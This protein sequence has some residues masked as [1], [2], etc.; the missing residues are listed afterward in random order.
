MKRILF[1]VSALVVG[2]TSCV[3]SEDRYRPEETQEEMGKYIFT[4]KV[5]IT[6]DEA[7]LAK[8]NE[9]VV[10]YKDQ[11][12]YRGTMAA[13]IELPAGAQTRADYLD[14]DYE[15]SNVS[16]R[17]ST[18][19][20]WGLL[21]FEDWNENGRTDLDYND[22]V[23]A[24][25]EKI[26]LEST[27]GNG[28]IDKIEAND[29][30]I[31]PV[32]MGN[33]YDLT[34]GYEIR[35]IESGKLLYETYVAE[36]DVRQQIFNVYETGFI[37]TVDEGRESPNYQRIV[38]TDDELSLLRQNLNFSI[39]TKVSSDKTVGIFWFIES[40]DGKFYTAS[41]KDF[42]GKGIYESQVMAGKE[43][44]PYGLV[45]P[46]RNAYNFDWT[47]EQVG[48]FKAYP[49]FN[50]YVHGRFSG[51]P[52]ARKNSDSSLFFDKAKVGF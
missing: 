28:I 44:V 11:E 24:F 45:L 47:H 49:D 23:C 12:V 5:R 42:L 22:F 29:F 37:N 4:E 7:E 43:R 18:I 39:S 48:L 21:L 9:L 41:A 1:L 15:F 30:W 20:R 10:T 32:A 17:Y 25:Y 35:E 51:D 19:T 33:T 50:D 46:N 52:F 40:K 31:S 14:Y 8:G 3:D 38:K 34:F 26:N 6:P 27:Q 16:K 36:K 13:T 2:L